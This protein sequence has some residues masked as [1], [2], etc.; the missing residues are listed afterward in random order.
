MANRKQDMI[1]QA[2]KTIEKIE[3]SLHE[4]GKEISQFRFI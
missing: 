4:F 3:T 1:D 2:V